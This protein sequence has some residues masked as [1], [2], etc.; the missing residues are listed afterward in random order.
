MLSGLSRLQ[1]ILVSALSPGLA[2]FLIWSPIFG[3][4]IGAYQTTLQSSVQG[5]TE[6]AMMGRI[7][8]LLALGSVG[9]TPIGSM[10]VGFLIDAWSARAAMGLGAVASLFGGIMLLLSRRRDAAAAHDDAAQSPES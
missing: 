4:S 6:P 8:S 1:T 10:I 5:A 7:A 2:F 9:T 3:F